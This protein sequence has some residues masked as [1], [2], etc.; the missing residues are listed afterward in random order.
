MTTNEIG[1]KL[2][3]LC[4]QGKFDTVMDT[5]YAKD[6]VSVEAGGPPDMPKEMKGLEAVAGKA[7]WW[8]ENHTVHS[9]KAEGPF[10]KGDQFIV[11]FL[12]D[13]TNKPSGK[14]MQLDEMALYTVKNDK[15]VRE[16]FFYTTD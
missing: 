15:I 1:K 12:F 16:E 4:N 13:I 11:R 14:R 6:I 5:L 9:S 2:V 10:P 8:N 3:E 7:K